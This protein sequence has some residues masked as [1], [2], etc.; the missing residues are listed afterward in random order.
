MQAPHNFRHGETSRY[1][2]YER[3]GNR[4]TAEFQPTAV[5]F[6]ETRIA[7]ILADS[8]LLMR[9]ASLSSSGL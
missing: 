7:R 8:L 4:L 2:A 1:E 3:H 9:S 5:I 6:A